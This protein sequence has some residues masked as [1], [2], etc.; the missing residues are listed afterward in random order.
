MPHVVIAG[1]GFAGLNC[2]RELARDKAFRITLIDRTNHH[3]FQP[4]LYQ[5]A[6][7]ELNPADISAPIRSIFR[8]HHN[9]SVKLG[10]ITAVH[11]ERK[12]VDSTAGSID[13]DYLVIATGAR[14]AYFG[15]DHWEETAPG[16]KTLEQATEIR[17]RVLTAFETAENSSDPEE[18][19]RLLTFVVVGG[20]PTGVE[21]AGA[22]AEMGRFTLKRDF[23]RIDPRRARV[24]LV[25]AGERILAPYPESLSDRAT[26]DLAKLGVEVRLGIPVSNVTAN[27]VQLGDDFIEAR[28]CLW[29]AGVAP[30]PLGRVLDVEC[31]RA[32][33]VMVAPDL[34]VPGHP[35]IAVAGD[36]AHF[37]HGLDAPLPG[38]A[39]V[40]VQQGRHI[41]K[42]LRREYKGKP[43]KPFRFRDYG[44]MATIGHN[45]AIA[46]IGPVRLAGYPAWL[47]WVFLHIWTLTGFRNRVFVML[48]WAWVYFTH[49]RGAR[50]ILGHDWRFYR[51]D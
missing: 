37:A 12:R 7:A 48:Q 49:R 5:V 2:A 46:K 9:V 42:Q 30:S 8:D 32:G 21:L 10:E 24:I 22:I 25:E 50:L 3:L 34:S 19:S 29:A 20:G 33:R 26:R 23:R 36:L 17:R 39:P 40:A 45:K 41:G 13:Y 38:V 28:T 44:S 47:A 16:L 35:E 51:K 15:N 4:L 6:M 11:P 1:A 43:R 27:G 31:D 18:Q 14:H